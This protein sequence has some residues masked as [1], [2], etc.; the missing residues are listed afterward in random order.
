LAY[1]SGCVTGRS[2]D[3]KRIGYF[4][5]VSQEWRLLG[6]ETGVIGW[7]RAGS[8][9]TRL[10]D[11]GEHP[12]RGEAARGQGDRGSL[13]GLASRGSAWTKRLQRRARLAP[14]LYAIH[15]ERFSQPASSA[16]GT[17]V[18]AHFC[19]APCSARA[20]RDRS[21]WPVEELFLARAIVG[22]HHS[23][24]GHRR[25][26]AGDVEASSRPSADLNHRPARPTQQYP[27]STG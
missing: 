19:P 3:R 13:C 14:C 15:L 4:D 26:I 25:R 8:G 22:A 10:A 2:P 7:V 20:I 16:K 11:R 5:A 12:P 23:V 27:F 17:N 21:P 18:W 24:A 9:G 6:G 1:R